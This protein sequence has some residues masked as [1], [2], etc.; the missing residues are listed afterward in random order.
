[1]YY[2]AGVCLI[3]DVVKG[4]VFFSISSLLPKSIFCFLQN[5]EEL[6]K[7]KCL[8]LNLT[9]IAVIVLSLLRSKRI[10]KNRGWQV[11][12]EGKVE[13]YIKTLL[14]EK[15]PILTTSH[16]QSKNHFTKKIEKNIKN[17]FD[18]KI[19]LWVSDLKVQQIMAFLDYY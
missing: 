14:F 19:L 4:R 18:K 5:W 1:M 7:L 3:I 16:S 15:T 9:Q 6:W 11:L 17:D 12:S 8:I 10:L 2:V 13:S